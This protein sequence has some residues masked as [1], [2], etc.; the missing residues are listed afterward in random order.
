MRTSVSRHSFFTLQFSGNHN[1]RFDP[2]FDLGVL[3]NRIVHGAGVR[4]EKGMTGADLTLPTPSLN[5]PPSRP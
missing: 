3:L 2:E 4:R 5:Y 1:Q